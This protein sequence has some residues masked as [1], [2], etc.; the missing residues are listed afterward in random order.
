V[1]AICRAGYAFACVCRYGLQQT[2]VGE[3]ELR[4]SAGSIKLVLKADG[5][6][7]ETI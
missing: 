2:L 5:N 3:Y 1:P 4:Q 7:V 6:F